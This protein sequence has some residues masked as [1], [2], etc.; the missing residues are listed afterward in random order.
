MYSSFA[1]VNAT[2]SIKTIIERAESVD[3]I[4]YY[5]FKTSVQINTGTG[6]KELNKVKIDNETKGINGT[7][8]EENKSKF[9]GK[10]VKILTIEKDSEWYTISI[11]INKPINKKDDNKKSVNSNNTSTTSSSNNENNTNNN[12][13]TTENK[14]SDNSAISNKIQKAEE[15]EG[16]NLNKESQSNTNNSTTNDQKTTE[17]K[18]NAIQKTA[19]NVYKKTKGPI[20]KRIKKYAEVGGDLTKIII[21]KDLQGRIAV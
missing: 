20:K 1:S 19:Q 2:K 7:N 17:N 16:S 18:N 3:G 8:Y 9:N 6:T 14:N 12:D 10:N 11:S 4:D 15:Q 13:K 5:I 21:P